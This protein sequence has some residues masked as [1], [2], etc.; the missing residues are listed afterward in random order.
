MSSLAPTAA[1]AQQYNARYAAYTSS[2]VLLGMQWISNKNN[3]LRAASAS[4]SYAR[5]PAGP[6]AYISAEPHPAMLPTSSLSQEVRRAPH[7]P[8][9]PG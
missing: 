9:R 7:P 3:L 6:A 8:D 4:I 2:Q 5:Y 1:F